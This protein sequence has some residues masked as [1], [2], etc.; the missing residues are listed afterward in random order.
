MEGPEEQKVLDLL[1]K[2]EKDCAGDNELAH[3]TYELKALVSIQ[4]EGDSACTSILTDSYTALRQSKCYSSIAL[5][6]MCMIVNH[7]MSS[8][9]L[10][11]LEELRT[12]INKLPTYEVQVKIP[13]LLLRRSLAEV[14]Y[15]L[16]ESE[17]ENFITVATEELKPFHPDRLGKSARILQLFERMEEKGLVKH[18]SKEIQVVARLLGDI[19]RADLKQTFKQYDPDRPICVAAM[20]ELQRRLSF[21]SCFGPF[22]L[23]HVCDSQ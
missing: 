9:N 8:P 1:K 13:K 11:P 21:N 10:D 7:A 22:P 12:H 6:L 17:A 20:I 15:D 2:I 23:L 5:S 14:A 4:G 16:T 19:R 3:A 18:T